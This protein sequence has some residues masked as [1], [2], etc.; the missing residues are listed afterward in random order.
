VE[1]LADLFHILKEKEPMEN[2][3]AAKKITHTHIA[4][5][6]GRAFPTI[7]DDDVKAFFGALKQIG[8]TGTMSIEGKAGNLEADAAA[9]LKVLKLFIFS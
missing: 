8:Y 6:E 9:A 2:I 5:L 3:V 7:C 1:L 4:L